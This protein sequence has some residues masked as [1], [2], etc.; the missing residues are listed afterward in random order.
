MV[1]N[2]INIFDKTLHLIYNNSLS[3]LRRQYTL[4]WLG[5]P[6]QNKES[7]KSPISILCPL[8]E[9]TLPIL[10]WSGWYSFLKALPPR[11]SIS[12]FSVD[13]PSPSTRPQIIVA[14]P[15][16]FI[17]ILRKS[18]CPECEKCSSIKQF[19]RKCWHWTRKGKTFTITNVYLQLICFRW[20]FSL[21]TS[22]FSAYILLF[23]LAFTSK[24]H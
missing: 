13:L 1:W 2:M 14:L 11:F 17:E 15:S 4:Y 5:E 7:K 20:L 9:Q 16:H 6:H 10:D 12:A 23:R 21:Y 22:S 24:V 3:V 19:S 8:N 18:S